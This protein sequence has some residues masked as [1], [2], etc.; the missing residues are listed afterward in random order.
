MRMTCERR[1]HALAYNRMR[2]RARYHSTSFVST[3]MPRIN[4]FAPPH[5]SSLAKS[6]I[7]LNPFINIM[8]IMRLSR[9][10][11]PENADLTPPPKLSAGCNCQ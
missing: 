5:K 11:M 3:M 2:G 7:S 10:Q 8:V 1:K 9:C 6:L 4:D